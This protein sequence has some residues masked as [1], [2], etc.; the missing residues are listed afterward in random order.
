MGYTKFAHIE[1]ACAKDLG[2]WLAT[3][4]ITVSRLP[5]EQIDSKGVV[6]HREFDADVSYRRDLPWQQDPEW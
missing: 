1:R 4:Y 3:L 2:R 5:R 6:L